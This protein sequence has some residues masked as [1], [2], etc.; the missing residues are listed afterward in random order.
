MLM[1]LLV[2]LSVDYT[3]VRSRDPRQDV[4][5]SSVTYKQVL[6]VTAWIQAHSPMIGDAY[7]E[8]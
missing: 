2:V 6:L 8:R 5:W 3:E 7:V 1:Q 4:S